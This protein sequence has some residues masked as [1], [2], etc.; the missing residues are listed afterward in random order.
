GVLLRAVLSDGEAA[1]LA[2][3][4][5]ELW[6]PAKH[7]D[8]QHRLGTGGA[9][10]ADEGVAPLAR[11]GARFRQALEVPVEAAVA[12]VELPIVAGGGIAALA[13]EG[14]VEVGELGLG[15]EGDAVDGRV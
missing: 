14:A 9:S 6:G 13:V 8:R 7:R 2:A 15:G 1:E 5:A 11:G 12:G 4:G 3:T 10:L